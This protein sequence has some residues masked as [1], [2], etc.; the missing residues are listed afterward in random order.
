M[1]KKIIVFLLIGI[2]VKIYSQNLNLKIT[3][4]KPAKEE[5]I[6]PEVYFAKKP[7]I[8]EKLNIFLQLEYLSHLPEKFTENPFEKAT[9]SSNHSG[10]TSLYD[11][12]TN[13]N[14]GNI[15]SL[16][17]SGESTGAYSESFD[18]YENFDL[19]NGNKISMQDIFIKSNTNE[20]V[21]NLNLIVRKKITNFLKGIKPS[22]N[23]KISKV[24]EETFSDQVLLYESCLEGVSEY[25][26]EYYKFYFTKTGITF[27]RERCSNHAM[28]GIDE[29]YSFYISLSYNQIDKYLTI[30]G[31]NLINN[32]LESANTNSPEGKIFKGKINAKYPITAIIRQI[33]KDG[34]LSINYWYDKVK[35][36]IEWSGNFTKNHFSLSEMQSENNITTAIIEADFID[37]KKIIGTWTN[38]TTKEVLKLELEEY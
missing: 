37:S 29:L 33:N 16:T 32:K 27:V 34:S 10:I 22:K 5:N 9:Y 4:L 25:N 30:Y 18:D 31:H 17:I 15:L 28:R 23:K 2:S 13:R 1:K 38:Q 6:F 21:K 7:K 35:E 11:W 20:L 14:L 12:K 36:P 3:N 19:R 24:D 8:A 26:L